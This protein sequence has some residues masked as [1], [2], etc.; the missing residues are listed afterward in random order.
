MKVADLWKDRAA[1]DNIVNNFFCFA[2]LLADEGGCLK[3]P[4]DCSLF[5]GVDP[6]CSFRSPRSK[7]VRFPCGPSPD[8]LRPRAQQAVC[9]SRMRH[10]A[11][12]LY[13]KESMNYGQNPGLPAIGC[14]EDRF[15]SGPVLTTERRP[16]RRMESLMSVG[17]GALRKSSLVAGCLFLA[18][19]PNLAPISPAQNAGAKPSAETA[20]AA[21]NLMVE[22]GHAL[23][24]RGRPDLAIQ[25][26]Q[27]VLVSDPNNVESLV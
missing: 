14:L 7:T 5:Q 27:Q 20:P 8:L 10:A 13:G 6:P 22:K 25:V 1:T 23:E 26:W 16:E 15:R 2:F 11:T 3:A 18:L 19:L 17:C 9:M 12:G 24:A 21:R 4:L